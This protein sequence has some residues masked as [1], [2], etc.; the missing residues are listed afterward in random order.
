MDIS[1]L[2]AFLQAIL[3]VVSNSAIS[4]GKKDT[5]LSYLQLAGILVKG[6]MEVNTALQTLTERV[7]SG[8]PISD[9]EWVVLKT[10]SD[11]AHE[12]IQQTDPPSV[13]IPKSGSASDVIADVQKS[14]DPPSNE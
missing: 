7:K 8:I 13:L 3:G 1:V 12:S 9:D 10:R 5:A 11:T 6:G 14:V 2:F 4:Q